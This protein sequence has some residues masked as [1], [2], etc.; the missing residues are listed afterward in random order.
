M[1]LLHQLA[2]KALRLFEAEQAHGLTISGLRTGLGPW[3]APDLDPI[4]ATEIAGLQ[5]SGPVGLAAGF[6]KNAEVPVAMSRF[7]FGWVECGTVT[8]LP[9]VGNPKPRLFRLPKDRAVINRLGFNNQGLEVFQ[10]NLT[11]AMAGQAACP[12]GANIG[13]NK[14]TT[15]RVGDYCDLL[16]KLWGIPNWFT[17]NI[18][19]PNTP[20]LRDLQTA[21][22]LD[23]LLGRIRETAQELATEQ[24]SVPIFLKVAPDLDETQIEGIVNAARTYGLS[25]LII[26]NTT[27]ARPDGLRSRHRQQ[28]GGLSG[29][30]LF[31]ASTHILRLFRQASKGRIALVGVGGISTADQAWEKIK[32][33]ASA[34]QLYSAIL[35]QGPYLATALHKGIAARLRVDG[36]GSL[37]AAVG[38]DQPV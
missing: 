21:S 36:F 9:Q 35:Y 37:A 11:S 31:T 7:G 33:G 24:S 28:K 4:L 30:P 3:R 23:E 26:S 13:A 18:S 27:L 29:E 10:S 8:P 1:S 20:G 2:P 15:D 38:A 12:I 6:D 19:S 17:I 14:D 32:A 22:A 34:V 5:V 16:R 25:G